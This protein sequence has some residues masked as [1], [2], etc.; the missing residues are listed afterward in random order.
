MDFLPGGL[1]KQLG[2]AGE[3]GGTAGHAERLGR[4]ALGHEGLE[5]GKGIGLRPTGPR[6]RCAWKGLGGL[7][8]LG[9]Q[10]LLELLRGFQPGCLGVF[11]R[12]H[13]CLLW[14]FP[15]AYHRLSGV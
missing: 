1:V 6:P 7:R 10:V 11:S 13:G 9:D 15:A 5:G 3:A 4:R 14:L 8:P 12:C 2:E